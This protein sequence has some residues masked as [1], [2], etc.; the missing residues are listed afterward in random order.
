[1]P[2]SPT[3]MPKS[4]AEEAAYWEKRKAELL[5]Q[6]ADDEQTLFAELS[7]LYASE[8]AKLEKEIAAYYQKYGEKNVIEY[9]R[10]L[11]ALSDDDRRLL[12]ERMEEFARKY[13]Q[14]AHLMPVRE[15]IYKLNELEGIQMAIRLQQLEIG[16]IEQD[17]L[18]EHFERMAARAA[19]L[20]AEQ[21]GFGKNFYGYDSPLVAETIGAAWAMSEAY[22][23][24]IWDNREK[25]AAYLN[26][27]FAKMIARGVSYEKC[28]AE[29]SKRFE[30]V[31]SRDIMRLVYTE[32]TFLFNEAQAQVHE[33]DFEFYRLSCVND[34]KVCKICR[35]LQREQKDNPV[36]FSERSP[37]VNFPPLHPWCRCSYT[38]EVEDWDAWIDA[39]VEA[40]G[41]DNARPREE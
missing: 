22:S 7:K 25:L 12:M 17:K 39:Y 34:A 20:A 14:Y 15:S 29:L 23:Q 35:E 5:E 40:R 16:A 33:Q 37:G 2:P 31:S 9:R 41:G 27:D 13:P 32:G 38:V 11:S 19:N 24:R 28:V 18:R 36:R 6:M 30:N 26:D 21:L 8:I 4:V 10:L 1:M 3:P